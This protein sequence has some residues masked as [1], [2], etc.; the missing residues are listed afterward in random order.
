MGGGGDG[1]G[2]VEEGRID[3]TDIVCTPFFCADM[4]RS[5]YRIDQRGIERARR[6]ALYS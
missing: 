3:R 1:E 6:E 2:E 5:D 4:S